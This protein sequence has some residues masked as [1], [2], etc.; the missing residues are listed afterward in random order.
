MT[1]SI[2]RTLEDVF[3][4]AEDQPTPESV[5]GVLGIDP[6]DVTRITPRT[7]R[8]PADA[9]VDRLTDLGEWSITRRE[10]DGGAIV[11]FRRP[12]DA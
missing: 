3:G 5:A 9:D 11:F 10:L 1:N 4:Q 7:F 12:K 2:K 8:V 6:R